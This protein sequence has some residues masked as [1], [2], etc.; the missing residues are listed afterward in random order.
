VDA[1]Q[2]CAPLIVVLD[3]VVEL[4][5][6]TMKFINI[7]AAPRTTWMH[8]CQGDQTQICD[9]PRWLA[10]RALGRSWRIRGCEVEAVFLC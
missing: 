6:R 5:L 2:V 3:M 4:A 9:Q 7:L 1:L 8:F 10:R